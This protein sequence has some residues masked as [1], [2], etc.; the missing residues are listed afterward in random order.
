MESE[1]KVQD[2]ILTVKDIR[3]IGQLIKSN[4][5]WSSVGDYQKKQIYVDYVE[6]PVQ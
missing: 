6:S 1:V 3:F 4:P 5:S 2:R